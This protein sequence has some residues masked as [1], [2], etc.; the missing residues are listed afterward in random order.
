MIWVVRVLSL[1]NERVECGS[2]F[3]RR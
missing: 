2:I 1:E 3:K